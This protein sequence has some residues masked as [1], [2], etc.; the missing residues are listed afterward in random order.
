MAVISFVLSLFTLLPVIGLIL[1]PII[2]VLI[3][4]SFISL[5]KNPELTGAKFIIGSMILCILGILV[6]F[7]M[8]S[9]PTTLYKIFVRS[10]QDMIDQSPESRD[11]LMKQAREMEGGEEIIKESTLSDGTVDTKKLFTSIANSQIKDFEKITEDGQKMREKRKESQ[12]YFGLAEKYVKEGKYELAL[13]QYDAN[14]ELY[15]EWELLYEERAKIYAKLENY[16]A[17]VNDLSR[18]L[19]F[20]DKQLVEGTEKHSDTEIN[21]LKSGKISPL[22][23]LGDIYC[24]IG[25]YNKAVDNYSKSIDLGGNYAWT[26]FLRGLTYRK[27]GDLEK[28]KQDWQKAV[29]LGLKPKDFKEF[30][31]DKDG[32]NDEGVT[33]RYYTNGNMKAEGH[34]LG[35]KIDGYY[36]W[37]NEDGTLSTEGNYENGK[38]EGLFKHYNKNGV[39]YK[40]HHYRNDVKID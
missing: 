36:K 11:A 9:H 34:F 28:T 31:P 32:K 37:Y 14:L 20:Y 12:K 29:T 25:D 10:T 24:K 1:L 38:K 8:V 23:K 7:Y 27:S 15:P 30:I 26:Y 21:S 4:V 35:N 6:S 18:A 40:E 17:A 22:I 39:V 13:K 33:I 19:E 16:T 2:A 3:V 5:K